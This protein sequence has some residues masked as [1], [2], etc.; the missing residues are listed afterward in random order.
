VLADS[1]REA[2]ARS[3][4]DPERAGSRGYETITDR[5][6]LAELGIT[7]A[8][9]RVPGLLVP[10]RDVR[11]AVWG[12]QYR[13]DAPRM[14]DAGRLIKYETPTGQRNGLDVP[15]GSGPALAD[16]S[17]PLWVTEGSKKADCA[18]A[19]GLCCVAFSG[20]WNWRGTNEVGGK[21]VI[22][23]WNDVALNG[24]RVVI[25][26]DGDVASKPTVRQAMLALG[27]YL[28]TR[29]AH[30]EY[31]HLPDTEDKTGLDD[32][33]M[34][35]TVEELWKLVTPVPPGVTRV[36]PQQRKK[37]LP[38]FGSIDGAAL[39]DDV[40]AWFAR[41]ICV[42]DDG[43]LDVLALWTVHTHLATEL[44]TSPRLLITSPIHE[45]GKT[46]LLEH[47]ERLCRNTVQAAV[48]SS[49]A[50][51]P[52]ML[53]Q[54]L[55]TVL[56]DE[57][58]RS[59]R[60]D[61]PGVEDLLSVINT[62]YRFGAARPVLMPAGNGEWKVRKMSTFAPVALAG[63]SPQ[64][65]DD[66]VS[67]TLRV[68][69]Y[70]DVADIAEETDWEFLDDE[71]KALATRIAD[72]ADSVRAM[73]GQTVVDLPNGCTRRARERWRPLKR[74]AELAGGR[75]PIATDDQIRADLAQEEAER[76][77]GLRHR[78][79]EVTV[80]DDLY[81][82]WPADDEGPLAFA[83]TSDLVRLLL[84]HNPDYWGVDSPYGKQLT[85]H[86]FGRLLSA[87]AKATS[88]R[89]GG[90]GPRGFLHSQLE[91]A[92]DRLAV[93]KRG[94][95]DEDD[96]DAHGDHADQRIY[97][98][99][100]Q[101]KADTPSSQ[102]SGAT[103]FTGE[104]GYG[105]DDDPNRINRHNSLHRFP[106]GMPEVGYFAD[107]D[108]RCCWDCGSQLTSGDP[109]GDYCAE[110]AEVRLAKCPPRDTGEDPD[111]PGSRNATPET[112]PENT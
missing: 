8:G 69:M 79:P 76:R 81:A 100:D 30:P 45:S 19:H 16:P 89:P 62:D 23:D 84:R 80:L 57:A 4:I 93:A 111:A 98:D 63:N 67:R 58:H 60:P 72:W 59:L 5:A 7:P 105:P 18:A 41:F 20:V 68:L 26:Y 52:R 33:L 11:G 14:T 21:V 17:E 47:L 74:I 27:A 9:R 54:E 6:R 77:D 83:A 82:V 95:S 12:Y 104:T 97:E 36:D 87:A 85:A 64:L 49:E 15:C 75:W 65:P 10:L 13:P 1:H 51:L 38:P 50:L 42:V 55:Y 99:D 102:E 107:F 2:L 22:A 28:A 24:R 66:T 108:D 90:R 78:P 48:I 32:F 109:D 96:Q 34:G 43:D 88:K 29:G 73:I 71:A 106:R 92:W 112:A 31:L 39:L 25:G 70:P 3:G 91:T 46:T 110:C 37:P 103:C 94:W 53:E 56:L 40:R 44:R 35:H 86:R 61:K 101:T